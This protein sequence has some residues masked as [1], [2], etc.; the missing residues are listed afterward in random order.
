MTTITVEDYGVDVT[1]KDQEMC[2][3]LDLEISADITYEPA[4]LSGP[5][6]DCNPDNSECEVT[7][8]KILHARDEDEKELPLTQ[9]LI[10]A[11]L[12]QIDG[13]DFTDE[14]WEAWDDARYDS[15]G[16]E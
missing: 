16:E 9:A 4:K 6:E 3:A 1:Y 10:D 2:L 13:T 12:L 5:P 8:I 11:C 7:E 14:L 15:S